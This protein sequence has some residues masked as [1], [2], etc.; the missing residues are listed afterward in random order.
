MCIHEG[1]QLE[2]ERDLQDIHAGFEEGA[3]AKPYTLSRCFSLQE[4]H[5]FELIEYR[6]GPGA[7]SAGFV[8][9]KK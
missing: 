1:M 7:V 3:R 6:K 5:G 9:E 2:F 8:S 4:V